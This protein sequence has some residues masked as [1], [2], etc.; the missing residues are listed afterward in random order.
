[1]D[2]QDM[3]VQ[4]IL[5]HLEGHCKNTGGLVVACTADNEE[6]SMVFAGTWAVRYLHLVALIRKWNDTVVDAWRIKHTPMPLET[7][8]PKTSMDKKIGFETCPKRR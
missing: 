5:E 2:I 8:Q 3:S 1:M 4:Q 6:D 7:L